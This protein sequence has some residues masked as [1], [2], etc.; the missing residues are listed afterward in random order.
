MFQ[1]WFD[2]YI[3]QALPGNTAREEAEGRLAVA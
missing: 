3:E 1:K 2:L